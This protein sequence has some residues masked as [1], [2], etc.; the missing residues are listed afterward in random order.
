MKSYKL[1][2]LFAVA[3]FAAGASRAPREFNPP[4]C[5]TA[6]AIPVMV[7]SAC[8][9]CENKCANVIQQCKD[10][11]VKACY[12]AAACLCQCNLD[13][14]GCGSAISALQKCVDDNTKLAREMEQ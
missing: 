11:S 5:R 4:S 10:G 12:Q 3:L 14:G 8:G 2:F 1:L 7:Q 9:A 6:A 13:A